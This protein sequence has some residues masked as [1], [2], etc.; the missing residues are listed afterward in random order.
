MFNKDVNIIALS[1]DD[2]KI[3]QSINSIETCAFE[4]SEDIRRKNANA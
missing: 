2:D 4:T 3:I 1:D